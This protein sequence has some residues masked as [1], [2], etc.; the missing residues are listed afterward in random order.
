MDEGW[1]RYVLD[2]FNVP[3]QT[4]RDRDLRDGSLNNK[5]DVLIIA[6]QRARDIIEGNAAGTFPSEFVGGIGTQGTTNLKSFVENGGSLICFDAACELAIKQFNLP[7]RNVL[8]GERPADF[9]CPGS[10]VGLEI[11][12]TQP[13]GRGLPSTVNAYFI[14]SS[15]FE[16][17]D[18][19]VRVV[20][21]YARENLL[22][23]G[24]LLGEEKLRNKI[25]LAEVRLGKGRI[26]LFA[27]R[28]QHRGQTWA[29]F[30]LIWNA[31][32]PA[33]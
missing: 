33:G 3:Y 10:I 24:W 4:V 19:S 9:Y 28:P 18:S 32:Q 8:E 20:A 31:I 25:A 14:N 30:P 6:S 23:S 22:R 12:R 13:L 27:F 15:A 5:Y 2:T 21:R 11:D 7:I 26:V 29:T 1:T 16:T 17:S